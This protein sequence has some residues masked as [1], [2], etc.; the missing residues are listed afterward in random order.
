[1][2]DKKNLKYDCN[3]YTEKKDCCCDPKQK[4]SEK[5]SERRCRN[6]SS[7]TLNDS[8]ESNKYEFGR[9]SSVNP[10]DLTDTL[11]RK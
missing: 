7:R 8:C 9:E 5:T 10:F 6:K 11:H 2:K 4:S 1:M 3:S